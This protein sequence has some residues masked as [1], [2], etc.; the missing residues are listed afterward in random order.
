VTHWSSWL[1]A[2]EL[3][4]GFATV[5]RI[6]RNWGLQPWRVEKFKFSTDPELD[7]K[8]RDVVGLYLR[9]PQNAVQ[10]YTVGPIRVLR[11]S[12]NTY[13]YVLVGLAVWS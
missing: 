10:L 2:G 5:A 11:Q 13:N 7:A 9:P 6:W 12:A 1:P 4:V 8:V 3:G